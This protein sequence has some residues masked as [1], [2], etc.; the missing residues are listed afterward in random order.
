MA[1]ELPTV[2][3]V[4]G[5]IGA[6]KSTVVDHLAQC[7]YRVVQEPV[8]A[9]RDH[10]LLGGMYSALQLPPGAPRDP[11]IHLDPAAFQ[12]TALVTRFAALQAA[13]ECDVQPSTIIVER[14]LD[15]DGIFAAETIPP[16]VGT[17]AYQAV[18]ETLEP[19]VA[20][21]H[22]YYVVLDCPVATMLRRSVTR[23]RAEESELSSEYFVRLADR[24][25]SW[26]ATLPPD[27]TFRVD[28]SADPAHVAAEVAAWIMR[29][30]TK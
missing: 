23:G 3:Y 1:G 7:G 13:L 4:C 10:G 21:H 8:A 26:A 9:W 6:G 28:A 2:F 25:A 19:R 17:T 14:S 11:E 30:Q 18:A 24:Y 5:G 22:P 15:E 27:R 16:G 29:H 12:I 20:P